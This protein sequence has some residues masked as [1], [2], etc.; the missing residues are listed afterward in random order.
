M[1]DRGVTLRRQGRSR[2]IGWGDVGSVSYFPP[3]LY[4]SPHI[5]IYPKDE[6][7]T[8]KGEVVPGVFQQEVDWGIPQMGFSSAQIQEMIDSLRYFAWRAG[9]PPASDGLVDEH[10]PL[11]RPA[12]PGR[13]DVFGDK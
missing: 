6:Y 4:Q 9:R 5:I 12:L 2:F 13:L 8:R 11:L 7:Y 3:G 1:D 10:M